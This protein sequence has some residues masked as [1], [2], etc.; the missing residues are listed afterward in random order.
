MPWPTECRATVEIASWVSW[1]LPSFGSSSSSSWRWGA[2]TKPC[3]AAKA[4]AIA[5]VSTLIWSPPL[6]K[7]ASILLC[8]R[9]LTIHA[10]VSPL[11]AAMNSGW[12][13][14]ICLTGIPQLTQL[15]H[16]HTA[17]YEGFV[18]VVRE[19]VRSPSR[20]AR[21][22]TP[23]RS[24]NRRGYSLHSNRAHSSLSLS[25]SSF[26]LSALSL[27]R[28]C[29][30][31]DKGCWWCCWGVAGLCNSRAF[32]CTACKRGGA[33]RCSRPS[34]PREVAHCLAWGE[35]Y[36]QQLRQREQYYSW[37]EMRQRRKAP[38]QS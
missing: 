37:G 31:V 11:S 36:M 16:R 14:V 7:G 30:V 15:T 26:A 38:A 29:G 2:T 5:N 9:S 18:S 17:L 33:R 25:P 27:F 35:Q 6:V 3:P 4:H 19:V 24:N 28:R 8:C 34:H 1:V 20:P 23:L 13:D 22:A 32:A 10:P 21:G 12:R